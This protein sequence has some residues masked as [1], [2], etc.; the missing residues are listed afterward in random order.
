MSIRASEHYDPQ[1]WSAYLDGELPAARRDAMH[2]H[3]RGCPSCAAVLRSFEAVQRGAE[4]LAQQPAPARPQLRTR[5]V[6]LGAS[7]IA[8]SRSRRRWLLWLAAAASIVIL[9][10]LAAA[11]WRGATQPRAAAP[12]V[13]A[14]KVRVTLDR[15]LITRYFVEP[16]SL[17]YDVTIHN[18][19]SRPL[20]II[21]VIVS[22]PLGER[23]QPVAAALRV[24]AGQ[25]LQRV[26]SRPVGE[27]AQLRPGSYRLLLETS[28]GRLVAEKAVP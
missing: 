17:E 8:Q 24:E 5:L 16:P 22:D 21:R 26:F 6:A 20:E 11:L 10:G 13:A 2:D 12:A 14:S 15:V 19:D 3:L 25:T 1:E 27:N 28:D 4:Q 7:V 9:A 18:G 23:E